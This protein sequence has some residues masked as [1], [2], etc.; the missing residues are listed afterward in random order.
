GLFGF[1]ARGILQRLAGKGAA[2]DVD[3]LAVTPE[4]TL[5]H[6][7]RREHAGGAERGFLRSA[8]P[9]A[10]ERVQGCRKLS[11]TEAE[12]TGQGPTASVERV[13]ERPGDRRLV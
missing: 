8:H 12:Q 2:V 1:L 4:C 6:H 9:F 10:G 13:V 7:D 3:R 11:E 5:V